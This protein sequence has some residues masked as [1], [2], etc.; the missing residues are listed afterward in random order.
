MVLCPRIEICQEVILIWQVIRATA[1]LSRISH[2]MLCAYYETRKHVMVCRVNVLVHY[3][4]TLADVEHKD[5]ELD[6]LSSLHA[7]YGQ[8]ARYWILY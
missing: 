7:G 3:K 2:V 4:W 6:M 5:Y 8:A 1:F